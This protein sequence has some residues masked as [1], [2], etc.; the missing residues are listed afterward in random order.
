MKRKNEQASNNSC[1][2]LFSYVSL[3][4]FLLHFH[5]ASQLKSFKA[6]SMPAFS[7]LFL[8]LMKRVICTSEGSFF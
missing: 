7:G 6:F 1:L 4:K 3:K 8:V 2:L 5:L